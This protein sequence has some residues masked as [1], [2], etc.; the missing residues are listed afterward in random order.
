MLKPQAVTP[1]PNP[2]RKTEAKPRRSWAAPLS[3]GPPR[4]TPGYSRFVYAMKVILPA[5]AAGLIVLVA[6]WPSL[7]PQEGRFRLGYS[8]I[9]AIEADDLTMINPRYVGTDRKN[10][11]F[12]VTADVGRQMMPDRDRMML[13]RPQADV[14]LEDGT[15][16]VLSADQGIYARTEETLDLSGAVNLYHDGGYEVRT[17]EARIDLEAGGASGEA[18]VEAQGPFGTLNAEGFRLIDKGDR[19]VFTGKARMVLRPDS[20]DAP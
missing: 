16:L 20:G 8:A 5:T 9:K 14:T 19:V 18:P 2:A 4:F 13:E 11:P 1:S 17:S 12:M 3:G 7:F 10:R 6:A 15:W